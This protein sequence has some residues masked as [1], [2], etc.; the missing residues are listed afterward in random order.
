MSRKSTERYQIKNKYFNMLQET[1]TV[2][3][4]FVK[5]YIESN[6]STTREVKDLLLAKY[7][8]WKPQLRPAQV[9][10]AYELIWASDRE[11]IVPACAAV[12]IKDTWYYCYDDVIDLKEDIRSTLI[13]WAFIWLSYAIAQ[14]LVV[15]F[16]TVQIQRIMQELSALDKN[17]LQ[18][19]LIDYKLMKFPDQLLYM[20]KADKYN[21]REHALRIWWIL[22][23]GS[24]LEI[25]RLWLIWKKFGMAYIIANDTWDFGKNLEDFRTGKYTLP[26]IRALEMAT[27]SDR[28]ILLSLFWKTI[29]SEE[30]TNKIRLIMVRSKAIDF[31]KNTAQ[32]LCNEWIEKLCSFNDSHAKK[33]LEFATTMTQRNK[34]YDVLK[35]YIL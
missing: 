16:S 30:E 28:Q 21:F 1:A 35:K 27:D 31:W 19:A 32:N 22:W 24:E 7:R 34:Y 9:R 6:F 8:F 12:E 26:I 13:W 17:N 15:N 25:E 29:L 3:D 20:E 4:P 14:E 18:G 23:N 2:V 10:L 11:K 5:G 33:M